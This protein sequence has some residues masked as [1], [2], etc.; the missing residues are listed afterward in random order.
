[1]TRLEELEKQRAEIEA[2]I[3]REKAQKQRRWKPSIGE[4]Y[5]TFTP[6]YNHHQYSNEDFEQRLLE[7]GLVFKTI[8]EA[9]AHRTNRKAYVALL[10][11]MYQFS[12]GYVPEAGQDYSAL[13]YNQKKESWLS[14][15]KGGT[16]TSNWPVFETREDAESAIKHFGKRLDILLWSPL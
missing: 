8:E 12:K 2:E 6:Y 13:Y 11:E 7:L 5:Y 1:M 15:L 3:A 16:L 4:E 10:D 9:K 14:G